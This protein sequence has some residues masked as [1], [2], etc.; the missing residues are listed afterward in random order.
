MPSEN[1]LVIIEKEKRLEAIVLDPVLCS[2][3]ADGFRHC[4]VIYSLLAPLFTTLLLYSYPIITPY[5][6]L[7][8]IILYPHYSAF[9]Y[10]QNP[11][12]LVLLLGKKANCPRENFILLLGFLFGYH[13]VLPSPYLVCYILPPVHVAFPSPM[14]YI[15]LCI[16]V[17]TYTLFV[18][19][20]TPYIPNVVDMVSPFPVI[21]LY[22]KDPV[23]CVV[24]SWSICVFLPPSPFSCPLDHTLPHIT[25]SVL[26]IWFPIIVTNPYL[27]LHSLPYIIWLIVICW[28]LFYP[29]TLT[30]ILF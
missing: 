17:G 15:L 26:P 6:W 5:L 8:H 18:F 25:Y 16:F 24:T 21:V 3:I 14:P 30:W 12:G 1:D 20:S 7:V 4:I 27:L 2:V 13:L 19:P 22:W 28:L 23:V 11:I 9:P 10:L 29:V